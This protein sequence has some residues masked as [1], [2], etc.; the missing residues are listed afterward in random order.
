MI[1]LDSKNLGMPPENLQ[2]LVTKRLGNGTS[3]PGLSGNE[4]EISHLT[5]L[6]RVGVGIMGVLAQFHI[7]RAA[8][9]GY[10]NTSAPCRPQ[11]STG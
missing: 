11:G 4:H 6:W 7:N 1:P 9:T 3:N 5:G 8:D 10:L 2:T